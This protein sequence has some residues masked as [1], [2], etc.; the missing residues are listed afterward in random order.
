MSSLKETIKRTGR[1]PIFRVSWSDTRLAELR[2]EGA[3][4][5]EQAAQ[6]R[7]A[8]FDRHLSWPNL[9]GLVTDEVIISH[10]ADVFGEDSFQ[11]VETRLYPKAPQTGKAWHIDV[12]QLEYYEPNLL[13]SNSDEFHSVTTWLA[14]ADVPAEMGAL[15][16]VHYKYVDLRKLVRAKR[17]QSGFYEACAAEA[18]HQRDHIETL[19]MKAGEFVMFD[20]RNLHTG[21]PNRTNQLRLGLVIRYCASHVRVD[22]HF[23]KKGDLQVLQI[24]D[25]KVVSPVGT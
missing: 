5:I 2:R 7:M 18:H 17:N 4:Y 20:P 22:P 1:S 11:L 24:R 13:N 3:K 15:Q 10:L 23:S 19:P 9:L 8:Q 6:E 14:L 16:L 25:R 12:R 21:A